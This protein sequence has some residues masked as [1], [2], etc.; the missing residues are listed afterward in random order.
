MMQ[1]GTWISF[2]CLRPCWTVSLDIARKLEWILS[3]SSG[4]QGIAFKKRLGNA[5]SSIQWHNLTSDPGLRPAYQAPG[6]GGLAGH[7]AWGT[8][9]FSEQAICVWVPWWK[10]TLRFEFPMLPQVQLWLTLRSCSL[11][12]PIK[13]NDSNSSLGLYYNF[14]K[15]TTGRTTICQRSVRSHAFQPQANAISRPMHLDR[16]PE[17]YIMLFSIIRYPLYNPSRTEIPARKWLVGRQHSQWHRQEN[18]SS[19]S[20]FC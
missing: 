10:M 1:V 20:E 8:R 3:L 2:G 16:N 17:P 15:E 19:A 7:A 11:L 9:T 6:R 13:K 4:A 12:R 14:P 18:T 5:A